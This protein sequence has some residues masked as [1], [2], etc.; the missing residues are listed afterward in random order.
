MRVIERQMVAATLNQ[1]AKFRNNN[2]EVMTEAGLT[3]VLLHGN[4]I[5]EIGPQHIAYG[6]AQAA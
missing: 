1:K 3:K 5:A 4:T 2:T 6:H